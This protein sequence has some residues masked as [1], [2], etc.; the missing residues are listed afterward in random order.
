MSPFATAA[1]VDPSH[2]PFIPRRG[3]PKA[4]TAALPVSDDG[5]STCP[6]CL[7]T[8]LV[9]AADDVLLPECGHLGTDWT[10]ANRYRP[11]TSCANKH[12]AECDDCE[13]PDGAVLPQWSPGTPH[14]HGKEL[15]THE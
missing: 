4:P 10:Q 5:W 7:R 14:T 8:W 6:H 2:T 13:D 9:V 3:R 15:S 11:C 1:R 12:E